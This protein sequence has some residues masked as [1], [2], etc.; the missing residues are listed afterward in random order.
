MPKASPSSKSK[1]AKLSAEQLLAKFD[2]AKPPADAFAYDR[3]DMNV[4]NPAERVKLNA[5][6]ADVEGVTRHMRAAGVSNPYEQWNSMVRRTRRDIY[7]RKVQ[8]GTPGLKK[9]VSEGDSWHLYPVLISEIVDQLNFDPRFAIFS[10][11]GA[12]DTL[13]SMWNE[14]FESNKGFQKSIG[15]ERPSIFL[16]NGGGNDLLQAK[17][18]ADGQMIGNLFFHLKQYQSG[19]TAAQ[20]VSS[21]IDTEYAAAEA[22]LRSIVSTALQ[23]TFLRKV[24]IHGY[25][26]PFPQND[27]WLGIPM[28]KRG[29]TSAA[30][31]R[32][33]CILLMDKFHARL[34]AIAQAFAATGRVVYV[35][36]RGCVPSKSEWHDEIHPTS[37]GFK[38]IAAR[39]KPVL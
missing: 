38:K 22:K 6:K 33:I 19:M 10:T 32:Q 29:I 36:V 2:K 15:N 28:A 24:V 25:D 35:D 21:S 4:S 11:D 13:D 5:A 34:S 14:R 12:G 26:Y 20:L 16:V 31:Q 9:I 8:S 18:G 30:L 23:F 3:R 7:R 39:I 27:L 17:P 1:T 37:A